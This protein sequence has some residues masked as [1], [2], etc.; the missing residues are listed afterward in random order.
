M[1]VELL[2]VEGCPNAIDYLPELAAVLGFHIP[3][4]IR[5]R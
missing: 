2:Y 3:T 5:M 1:K 4:W